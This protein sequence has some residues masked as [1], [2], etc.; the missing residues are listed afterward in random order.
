MNK[1]RNAFVTPTR[2][3]YDAILAAEELAATEGARRSLAMLHIQ[4]L[5]KQLAQAR[6]DVEL[7]RDAVAYYR[8]HLE[9]ASDEA[10]R[11]PE[12]TAK[13]LSRQI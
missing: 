9:E 11:A 1:K 6:L 7:A 2:A 13:A 8:R 3:S 10:L 5:E 4:R 12:L